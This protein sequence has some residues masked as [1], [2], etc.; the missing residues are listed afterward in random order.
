L[1]KKRRRVE[2]KDSK[3]MKSVQEKERKPGDAEALF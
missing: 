1:K 2:V 3:E